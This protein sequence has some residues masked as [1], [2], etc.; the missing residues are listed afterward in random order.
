MRR[1]GLVVSTALFACGAAADPP[2][3][4]DPAAHRAAASAAAP[5]PGAA[6]AAKADEAAGLRITLAHDS[7]PEEE[8]RRQLL[9]LA[10]EHD[11][12]PWLLTKAVSVDEAAI[13]HSHPVLTLHTRHLRDDDQLLS[14]FVHEQMHWHLDGRPGEK[15]AAVAELRSLFPKLPVGFPEGAKDE[16][17]SYEHLL[18]IFLEYEGLKSLV[19]ARRADQTFDFWKGDHYRALYGLVHADP[20]AIERVARKHALFPVVA[21]AAGRGRAGR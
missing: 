10:R 11:L 17:S 21:S 5:A 2:A 19:G 12:S 1:R 7:A 16:P 3:P 6:P 18:V 4:A 20:A 15:A 9:R 13:P 14:T 8:T